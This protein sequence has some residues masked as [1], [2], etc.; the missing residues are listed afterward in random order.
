MKNNK[1]V[2]KVAWL[3]VYTLNGGL[4]NWILMNVIYSRLKVKYYSHSAWPFGSQARRV[5]SLPPSLL[6][7]IQRFRF[8]SLFGGY[9]PFVEG[10]PSVGISA[11]ERL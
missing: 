6:Q 9:P 10:Y 8:S 2:S 5:V 1:S 7:L 11:N 4:S 3:A